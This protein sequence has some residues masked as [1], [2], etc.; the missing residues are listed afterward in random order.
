MARLD[1]PDDVL[2]PVEELAVFAT[3][4]AGHGEGRIPIHGRKAIVNTD[5]GKVLGVVGRDYRLVTNRQALEMARQCCGA[6]FPDT[7]PAEWDVGTAD[8]PATGSYCRIDLTHNSAALDFTL[9]A[10]DDKPEAFGPFIRVTNS[11]NG[12][13]AL[14]FD[15]GLN[16]KVCRNGLIMP[17]SILAPSGRS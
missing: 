1:R 11:Y 4:R 16:R 9:V 14:A 15:I 6:V 13:R 8:A 3:P 10:P 7:R 12:L 5:T 2:F 17:D